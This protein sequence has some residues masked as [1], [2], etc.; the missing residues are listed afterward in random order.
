[1]KQQI[2]Q[3]NI[4]ATTIRTPVPT[5][6]CPVVTVTLPIVIL[7]L[8]HVSNQLPSFTSLPSQLTTFLGF[9]LLKYSSPL[10]F[11]VLST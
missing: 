6:T 2:I 4:V 10:F 9:W 7:C 1:M 3:P 8:C 11:L 5:A